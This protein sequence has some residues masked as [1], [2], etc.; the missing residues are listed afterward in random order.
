MRHDAVLTG[1]R[2]P[3]EDVEG[4][5]NVSAH[6]QRENMKKHPIE[7]QKYGGTAD[8][9]TAE[10]HEFDVPEEPPQ[11]KLMTPKECYSNATH[12]ALD[13]PKQYDYVEGVYA[14]PHLPFPIE[15][16]WLVDKNTGTVVDPTLGWQPKA[17]YVGVAYPKMFVMRKMLQNKYYGIHSDGNMMNPVTLG[18][19]KDFNYAKK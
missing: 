18:L 14:S 2:T 17:R 9:I 1:E 4:Y 3:L 10:G 11:I 19:D 12:M 8:F 5:L 15:H 7:G 16:A 6:F 13:N